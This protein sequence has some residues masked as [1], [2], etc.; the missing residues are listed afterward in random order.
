MTRST[1]PLAATLPLLVLA[2]CATSGPESSPRCDEA[3]DHVEACL[4]GYVANRAEACE[5]MA[6]AESERTLSLSC[7][8]LLTQMSDGKADEVP[9]LRGI[10]IRREGNRTTFLVPLAQ[11]WAGD[12]AALLDETIT[13]FRAAM[14]DLHRDLAERGLDLGAVLTGPGAAEFD[15]RYTAIVDRLVGAEDEV[16]D[17]LEVELGRS[18]GA[19]RTLS[20]WSRY[21]LPQAFI[22]YVSTKFTVDVG[23]SAGVSATAMIVVQ[24]WLAIAVDHSQREPVVVGKDY[25]VDV[26]ILGAPNVDIGIGVGGGLPLRIGLGAVFGPLDRPTDLAGWALGLSGSATLPFI[27]GANGKFLSVLRAPPLFLLLLGYTT[28]TAAELEVHGNLQRIMDLSQFLDW[29]ELTVGA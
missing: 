10:R 15:R 13:R 29:I 22:A 21:V 4:P 23:V 27:G 5:G 2:A 28:G 26:A 24:L 25:E 3:A 12:R 20:T 1:S 9:A 6:L 16:G 11:T 14:T 7:P 19:P 18:Y 8:E 17:D